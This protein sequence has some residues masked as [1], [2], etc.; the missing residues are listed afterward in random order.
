MMQ[1]YVKLMKSEF[2]P[3]PGWPLQGSMRCRR[4]ALY[5]HFLRA[6]LIFFATEMFIMESGNGKGHSLQC[7]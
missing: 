5:L 4:Q 2:L 6:V 7:P 1:L 3:A